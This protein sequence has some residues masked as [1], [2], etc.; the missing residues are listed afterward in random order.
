MTDTPPVW[1]FGSQQRK[2]T[3]YSRIPLLCPLVLHFPGCN[4]ISTGSGIASIRSNG[5]TCPY[6]RLWDRSN[7]PH[8]K[9]QCEPAEQAW[10]R[11]TMLILMPVDL[12][13]PDAWPPRFIFAS[14]IGWHTP[15]VR[16]KPPRLVFVSKSLLVAEVVH[17]FPQCF[18]IT[19]ACSTCLSAQLFHAF[20]VRTEPPLM[21]VAF[22]WITS[23]STLQI[24]PLVRAWLT[25][26]M[27]TP[28][29][30][31]LR[32]TVGDSDLALCHC[33]VFKQQGR[34]CYQVQMLTHPV[35][36]SQRYPKSDPLLEVGAWPL[37]A[38]VA[39]DLKIWQC[40][41]WNSLLGWSGTSKSTRQH[42]PVF[43]RHQH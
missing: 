20:N 11:M 6:V 37:M 40:K 19:K 3:S 41:C 23:S 29:L 16:V 30:W 12:T 36:I 39:P 13:W 38:R 14:M 24:Y 17:A 33:A 4:A 2:A 43:L 9:V 32:T 25:L 42:D 8:H 35:I 22:Q 5:L 15:S 31:S 26:L 10:K 28:L 34:K 18:L 1:N 7:M 21:M 27:L